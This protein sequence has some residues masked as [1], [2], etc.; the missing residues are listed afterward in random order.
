[1][2]VVLLQ[3]ECFVTVTLEVAC[4]IVLRCMCVVCNAT[5]TT[6]P[7]EF[8]RRWRGNLPVPHCLCLN[9]MLSV[10]NLGEGGK[11]R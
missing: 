9:E 8:A 1:V 7:V 6:V 10:F 3:A 2:P 5:I 11:S 4:G